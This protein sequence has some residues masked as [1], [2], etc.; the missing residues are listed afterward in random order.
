QDQNKVEK[1]ILSD[2]QLSELNDT[3]VFKMFHDPVTS[4][5]YYEDGY[6]K[7]IEGYIHKVD[8]YERLLYL[9]E[10][11]IVR[12]VNLKDIVEIKYTHQLRWEFFYSLRHS[13]FSLDSIYKLS[14]LIITL[15]VSIT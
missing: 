2:D 10:E 5:S 9:Y 7:N 13:F 11:T 12:K 8:N 15:S 6:I 1:P 14:V 3:L 4:V